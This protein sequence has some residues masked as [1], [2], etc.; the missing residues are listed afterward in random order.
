MFMR[1]KKGRFERDGAGQVIPKTSHTLNPVPF[2]LY[3]PALQATPGTFA[4]DTTSAP[5]PYQLNG[6]V[7]KPGLANIAATVL[8]L[9]GFEAPADYAPSLLTFQP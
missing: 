5:A 9:L 4:G 6:Q 1:D 8:Q 2:Y 3:D 7:E